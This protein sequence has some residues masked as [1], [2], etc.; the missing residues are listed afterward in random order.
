MSRF[1]FSSTHFPLSPVERRLSLPNAPK[2]LRL[3][4]LLFDFRIL[5][6]SSSSLSGCDLGVIGLGGNSVGRRTAGMKSGR[7]GRVT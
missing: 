1:Q 2:P 7:M 5:S 6:S 4:K 3:M